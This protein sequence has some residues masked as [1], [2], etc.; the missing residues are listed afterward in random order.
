MNVTD[1]T[2][3]LAW[4]R[5]GI[6]ASDAAAIAGLD[7][8]RGPMSIWL[9]KTGRL[10]LEDDEVSEHVLWGNLLE[11]AIAEEFERRTGL[12]VPARALMLEYTE[13]PGRQWMRAT[14]DGLVSDLPPGLHSSGDAPLGV[15]EIKTVAGF[16]G[17]AWADGAMPEHFTLQVQHQLAVTGLQHAWLAVLFGGQRMEIRELERDE[18]LIDSLVGLEEA[19]WTKH[20]LADV[21]PGGDGLEGTTEDLRRAFADAG[22]PAVDLPAEVETLIAEREIGKAE[23]EAGEARAAIA[24]QALMA[25][26][27]SAEVGMLGGQPRITW[28]RHERT[29][30]DLAGLRVEV[31]ELVQK[32]TS[33]SPYRVLRLVGA[34]GE[35]S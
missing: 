32:F 16:K 21:P 19:F 8:Y 23:Q 25:M 31:P 13:L 30:V 11:P 4:R 18:E 34:K 27:G 20:V 6:G 2:A 29:T 10:P 26:L 15:L 12:F 28:K 9:A 35:E 14:I 3:W 5:E 22:G 33:M 24:S 17:A 1:R 7:P